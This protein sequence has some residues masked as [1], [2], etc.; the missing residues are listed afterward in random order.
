MVT[1]LELLDTL[2]ERGVIIDLDPDGRLQTDAAAGIIDDELAM[3]IRRHR[4]LLVWTVIGRRSGH[5]W[6]ACDHC[7]QAVLLDPQPRHTG[8]WAWPRCYMTPDCAGRHNRCSCGG[9]RANPGELDP[10]DP[11]AAAVARLL[12]AFNTE[13]NEPSPGEAFLEQRVTHLV[14]S[15]EITVLL[16]GDGPDGVAVVRFRPA[17]WSV[18]LDAYLEELYVTPDRRGAGL[19]RALLHAVLDAARDA[20]AVRIELGTEEPTRLR[21]PCTRAPGS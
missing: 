8:K 16:V 3:Q 18:G 10:I 2:D 20:G 7:G 6:C 19:G 9:C 5:V 1:F 12:D 11:D 4:D 14:D 15:N 21:G 13:F 17:L